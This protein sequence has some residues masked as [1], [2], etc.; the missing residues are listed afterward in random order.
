MTAG[1]FKAD[2]MLVDRTPCSV[3]EICELLGCDNKSYFINTFKSHAGSTPM[4]YRG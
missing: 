3:G 2:T 1:I 4:E